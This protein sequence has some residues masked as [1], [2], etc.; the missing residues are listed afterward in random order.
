[1][2]LFPF[3]DGCLTES[4]SLVTSSGDLL[5]FQWSEVAIGITAMYQCPCNVPGCDQVAVPRTASRLCGGDIISGGRWNQPSDSLCRFSKSE[6][7]S[8]G[9]ALCWLGTQ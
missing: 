9:I 7:H 8:L 2:S 3:P 1:M 6:G 4:T 5:T